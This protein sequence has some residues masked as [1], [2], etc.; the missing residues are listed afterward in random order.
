M[1]EPISMKEKINISKK[2][3]I[4]I[5]GTFIIIIL[6]FTALLFTGKIVDLGLFSKIDK[7]FS[8]VSPYLV[9]LDSKNNICLVDNRSKRLT[10]LTP[11]GEVVFSLQG[12][13]R[14]KGDFYLLLDTALDDHDYIYILNVIV[15]IV[16]GYP[17]VY[18]ILRYTPEGH[19]D[20]TIFRY[21]RSKE[22]RQDT[23]DGYILGN[24]QVKNNFVYYVFYTKKEGSQFFKAPING[25]KPELILTMKDKVDFINMVGTEPG[26]I[27]LTKFNGKIYKVLEDGSLKPLDDIN[28]AI[29]AP[30]GLRIDEDKNLYVTDIDTQNIFKILPGNVVST[31][32]TKDILGDQ[33]Y[34]VKNVV[35]RYFSLTSSGSITVV[36]ELND[37]ILTFGPDGKIVNKLNKGYYSPKIIILNIIYKVEF[38]ILVIALLF[39]IILFY[40]KVLFRRLP[41]V[42]KQFAVF[43]P[44]IALSIAIASIQ[45][46]NQLYNKQ[47]DALYDH[48]AMIAQIGSEKIDGDALERITKPEDFM[49]KDYLKVEKEMHDIMHDNQ[50][51]WNELP[52]SRIYKFRNGLC[53][54][55]VDWSSRYGVLYPFT[56][57]Q[58]VHKDAYEKGK[59]GYTRYSDFDS[60][61]LVGVAPIRNSKG[62]ITGVY[63]VMI[64]SYILNEQ[65]KEFVRNLISTVTISLVVIIGAFSIFIYL[66]LQALG[67]L[68]SALIEVSSGMWDA[69]IDIRSRDEIEDLGKGFNIMAGTI[70]SYIA[71]I[72]NLNRAYFRFVPNEFL[73]FLEKQSILEI[74]LGNQVQKEM[75]IMFSDI[76]S[77][78]SLSEKMTPEENFNFINGYLKR[79]GPVIRQNKGFIDKYIGDA[80]MALFAEKAE[81]G[82]KT[83]I[84]MKIKLADYNKKRQENGLQEISIGVGLHTG[85]LM[86]GIIGEEERMDGTVISD[87]VNL[88]SRLE[89]LTK[90][91]GAGI[92]ISENTFSRIQD[93]EKKYHYRFLD[94]VRVKGKNESVTIYEILDGSSEGQ[95]EL[96]TKTRDN[97][98][99]AL[100]M[101]QIGKF[102]EAIQM[103]EQI[104]KINDHDKACNLF[105]E[106]CEKYIKFGSPE[107]WDGAE[108]LDEK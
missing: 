87:N 81:D 92:I 43:L 42:F 12:G 19:Y 73:K 75:T 27:Y 22:E 71:Q 58:Q 88:A 95:I 49:G 64:D 79:M 14:N 11:K 83:G 63:E 28:K 93:I 7:D 32:I 103:F 78:T 9:S 53:Y 101:Y 2:T 89:G 60:D 97:Y 47:L 37:S 5:V 84:E 96:K 55:T 17:G 54:I 25:G 4:A 108:H 45:T 51:K 90:M 36:D 85:N 105:I 77:F 102:K 70:R 91:Y 3:I 8:F 57:F 52:Y 38:V 1:A 66:L 44:L 50:D 29:S 67:K 46:Y 48:V 76:R 99:A 34:K 61:L 65:Q 35:F 106:R 80:I 59:I 94:K 21:E 82:V 107:N 30:W 72:T 6:V 68:R 39:L 15:D 104:L 98:Y 18:E 31:F 10:K 16:D 20:S 69:S 62:V 56:Y 41:L 74:S 23:S 26:N 100:K 33:G 86:L 13:K 40:L 24:I